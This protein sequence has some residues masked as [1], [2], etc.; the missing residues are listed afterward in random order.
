MLMDE[1]EVGGILRRFGQRDGQERIEGGAVSSLGADESPFEHDALI[2]DE[3]Q[4]FALEA[5]GIAVARSL[6]D[7]IVTANPLV[8]FPLW[9]VSRHNPQGPT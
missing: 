3:F 4:D 6:P 5:A 9:A 2:G 1:S 7:P 8:D